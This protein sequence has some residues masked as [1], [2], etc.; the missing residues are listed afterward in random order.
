MEILFEGLIQENFLG[1]DRGL[2]IQIQKAQITPG[3]ILQDELHQGTW[4]SGYSKST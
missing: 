2:D 3:D 4:L 1:L